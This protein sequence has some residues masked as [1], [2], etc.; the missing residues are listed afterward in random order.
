MTR[1]RSQAAKG[2]TV[3]STGESSMAFFGL[4][5]SNVGPDLQHNSIF[6]N[7]ASG[8]MDD[9]NGENFANESPKR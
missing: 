2:W 6:E 5:A 1:N 3:E 7:I 8:T 4:F 9:L